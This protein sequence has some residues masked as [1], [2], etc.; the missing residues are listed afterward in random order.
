[1]FGN[2][3]L[4]NVL[5][6]V[7]EVEVFFPT[8]KD[9]EGNFGEV[10][11]FEGKKALI[12]KDTGTPLGIV[13]ADWAPVLNQTALDRFDEI[14][15]TS[16]IDYK[17][18]DCIIKDGGAKTSIEIIFPD[19]NIVAKKGDEMHLRGYL[20]NGFNGMTSVGLEL[21][22]FRLICSNGA[23]I[24]QKDYQLK[25]K[26]T[27]SAEDR[28][29]FAFANYLEHQ[30]EQ[31]HEFIR[32]LS[33]H[34]ISDA[35][36]QIELEEQ[37]IIGAKKYADSINNALE[38]EL[39]DLGQD[40]TYWTLYNAFSRVITHDMEVDSYRKLALLNETTK[41]AKSVWLPALAA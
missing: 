32:A 33:S 25:F 39:R 5:F 31:T 15:K 7:E 14:C 23:V 20:H 3:T 9:A 35:K 16:N 11:Q 36:L 28:L 27:V 12:R 22:F 6:D 40:Q 34:H 18:G 41:R 30:F 19:R 38:I 24:G 8:D 10:R 37:E 21:G 29:A 26:H 4:E 17:F 1:M 2:T 13:G